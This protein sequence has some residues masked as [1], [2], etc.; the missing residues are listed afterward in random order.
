MSRIVRLKKDDERFGLKAGDLLEVEPY[1]L[2]PE[3][4]TVVQRLSDG[5]DPQ[6]NVYS[7]EVEP[8]RMKENG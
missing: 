1:W 2:D 5:F 6:C 4:F 7:H 8:V 3:K